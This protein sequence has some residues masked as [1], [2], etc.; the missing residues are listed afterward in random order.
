MFKGKKIVNTSYSCNELIKSAMHKRRRY[1]YSSI[2][3]ITDKKTP[4]RVVK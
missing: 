1:A 3:T 2:S 4:L